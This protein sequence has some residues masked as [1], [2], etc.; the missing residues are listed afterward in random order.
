M[1][2]ILTTLVS[3]GTNCIGSCKSNYHTICIYK[4]SKLSIWSFSVKANMCGLFIVC[5]C[6]SVGDQYFQYGRVLIPLIV[7]TPPHVCAC[8][9]IGPEWPTSYAMVSFNVQW[10]L[11]R[12]KCSFCWYW[13][14]CWPSLFKLIVHEGIRS[15]NFLFMRE[16]ASLTIIQS[17][18]LISLSVHQQINVYRFHWWKML[19]QLA[20]SPLNP[21]WVEI[22]SE[23]CQDV[24]KN[25]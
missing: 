24:I 25:H 6:I 3:I 13:W 4:I 2:F 22:G 10:S 15:V 20:Y 18:I 21:L 11:V 9:R 17:V 8:R 12:S 19:W 7:L 16:Y 14:N 1:G 5:I 23:I